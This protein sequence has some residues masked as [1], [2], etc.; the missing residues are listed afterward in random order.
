MS[1]QLIIVSAPSGAGKT[2]MLKRVIG[3]V[4]RLSFSVSH[5]T[6]QPRPGEIE[7]RDYYFT[8]DSRFQQMIAEHGFIEWARVHENYYGTALA[9][10]RDALAQ[11]LDV[12]LDIDVQGA[13][14]VRGQSALPV[15]SIFIM[16]PTPEELERRLRG[17]RTE[18]EKGLQGRIRQAREEMAQ[19]GT[20]DYL[21]VNEDLDRAV[22]TL[23]AIIVA[24]RAKQR[25]SPDGEPIRWHEP[26]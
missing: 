18:D 22:D 3:T 4:A 11:D 16:A 10:L 17:R 5:T 24:E 15:Y 12:L 6:R 21:I 9:P 1:G 25:R 19:A 13:A 20:Y 23:C 2:T 7:G 26:H 8:D 14:I